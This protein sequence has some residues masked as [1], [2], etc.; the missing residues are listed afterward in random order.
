MNKAL[1]VIICIPVLASCGHAQKTQEP[2]AQVKTKLEA[3]Q[4]RTG[5]VIIKGFSEI[6]TV[7]GQYG[8]FVT[9]ESR[10]FTDASTGKKEYGI[11]VEVK[12]GGTIE[13]ENTSYVDYDEIDSLIKGIDYISKA[14][15]SVTKLKD[16]E[17]DY[18]TKGDLEI[19][20]FSGSRGEIQAAVSS[21]TIGKTNAFFPLSKLGDIRN[22]LV[23]A[24]GVLDSVSQG[25]K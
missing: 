20:T 11:T 21:G 24:K 23:N 13:Q 6:G 4:A 5:A 7:Q 14:D 19:S 2:A 10:E 17:A 9:V 12:K 16:F 1:S 15:A 25:A 3:F 22:L 18:R 8:T